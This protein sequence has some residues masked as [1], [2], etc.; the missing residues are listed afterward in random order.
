[1]V[2]L[3]CLI[4]LTGAATAV[5]V[6]GVDSAPTMAG[7]TDQPA[8]KRE[9]EGR[10]DQVVGTSPRPHAPATKA[11]TSSDIATDLSE[12]QRAFV[13]PTL[14]ALDSR[15]ASTR[16]REA[17]LAIAGYKRRLIDRAKGIETPEQNG[18]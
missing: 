1:M 17:R 5:W 11:S 14:D 7:H 6:S 15:L 8:K 10:H 16:S 3:F 13:Q 2:V 18:P 12:H 9:S 4:L